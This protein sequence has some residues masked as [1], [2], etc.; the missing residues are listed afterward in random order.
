MGQYFDAE[1]SLFYN[2]FGDYDPERGKAKHGWPE[3]KMRAYARITGRYVESDL[4]SLDGGLNTYGYVGGNSLHLIDPLGLLREA[5]KNVF[6][7]I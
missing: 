2:Y 5:V 7:I 4:I 3:C 1:V 6:V